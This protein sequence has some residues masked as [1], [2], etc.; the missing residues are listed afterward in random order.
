MQ[1]WR[2]LQRGCLRRVEAAICVSACTANPFAVVK[3]GTFCGRRLCGAPTRWL[4]ND[5][6]LAIIPINV[7]NNVT[8]DSKHT[9]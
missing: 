8:V 3:L 9:Q 4:P 7:Q 2:K 6:A 1:R 5:H